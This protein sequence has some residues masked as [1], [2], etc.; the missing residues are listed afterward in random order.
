MLKDTKLIKLYKLT[1]LYQLFLIY[2]YKDEIWKDIP[3]YSNYKISNYGRV[4]SL[5]KK[6]EKIMKLSLDH[7]LKVEL[8]LNNKGKKWSVHKLVALGFN[9]ENPENKP[10]LDH[11]NRNNYNNHID[12]LRYATYKEQNLNQKKCK[13]KTCRSVWKI[14]IN[15]NEKKLFKS[16]KN[17]SEWLIN[18]TKWK[19][20][21]W[22]PIYSVCNGNLQSMY[23]Y[24]WEYVKSDEISNKNEEWKIIDKE[25]M[26]I[27]YPNLSEEDFNYLKKYKISNYGRLYGLENKIN[28]GR[29]NSHGYISYTIN[30]V[31]DFRANRLVGIMFIY[32]SDPI[33]KNIVHHKDNN[34]E[35]NHIDNLEWTT[36][37]QNTQYSVDEGNM[38]KNK[39]PIIQYDL[40][41]NKIKEFDSISQASN[42]LE[43]NSTHISMCCNNKVKTAGNFIFRFSNFIITNNIKNEIINNINK[44]NTDKLC[45]KVIQYDL[46]MNKKNIFK[47]LTEAAKILGLSRGNIGTCCNKKKG[48][49][50]GFIFRFAT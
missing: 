42:I 26:K 36:I 50:G 17:A 32:N 44:N 21:H 49:V 38:N 13:Q 37:S 10:T 46:K 8:S 23:G 48:T 27:Y 29:K 3:E 34:P 24:K 18:N 41:M 4:K 30:K 6:K 19:K 9:L 1:R 40:K 15:T 16:T 43:I 33:N 47:S 20:A 35:N 45:K 28:K 39:K 22:N 2:I 31:G 7:Y 11:I 25:K 5:K 12:N 14:D